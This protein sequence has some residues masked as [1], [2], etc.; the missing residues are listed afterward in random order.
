MRLATTA[1]L[2]ATA[3]ALGAAIHRV[4]HQPAIGKRAADLA[5][6]LVR[7]DPG[8]VDRITVERGTAKTVLVKQEGAWFFAESEQDR[9]DATLAVALLDRLNHL[10]IVDDLDKGGDAPDPVALGIAGDHAIRVTV[11]G[12]GGEGDKA[13]EE[14]LVLGV[15]APRTGSIYAR[16]EDGGPGVF[17]VDGNPRPWLESP[18]AALRDRKLLAAP[19]AAVDQLVIRQASGEVALQRRITPPQ[20]DWALAAPIVSWADREAMDRL[21]AAVAALQIEEVVK[22]APASEAIPS[23]LPADAAVLQMRIHGVPQPLVLYLRK[24]G[25]EG[26]GTAVI[27]ARASDRPAVY[28][29]KSDFLATLPRSPND[30]RDRTLARLPFEALESIR[31]QSPVDPDVD[32]RVERRGPGVSPSWRVA[33]NSK[34]LPA[35]AAEVNSLVASVNEA[36]IQRFVSDEVGDLA[37]YGLNRPQ[38]RIHFHLKFPG[39]PGADGS[40]SEARELRR[41]LNLGWKEGEEEHLY[42]NFDGEPHVYELDPTFLNLVPTHPVKWKSLNV[43]TFNPMHLKSITREMPEQEMLK[44]DYDYRLD[45]WQASLNGVEVTPRLDILSARRLRDRLGSLT[46]SDWYLTLG[47]AYEALRTPSATFRIVTS[48]LDRAINEAVDTIRILEVAPSPLK[49]PQTNESLYFGRI[50]GEPDV[51]FLDR[52]TYGDLI[53][54]VTTARPPN[55]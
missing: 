29:L 6:V 28:R 38:R 48:E 49:M 37:E 42:A 54:G 1:V 40:P 45:Q 47:P 24:V 19:V 12:P 21:L 51:F 34:L 3:L 11:S 17:V 4:D 26:E 44:L 2:G 41:V 31:I 43:L 13:V 23:P 25:G 10:G 53:R 46:A 33:L 5:K 7:F 14:R 30:L 16:R 35:N 20:Q 27:E 15:E 36:A 8:T 39:G 9:V 32:L 50:A 52:A 55:P 22:D 18:L